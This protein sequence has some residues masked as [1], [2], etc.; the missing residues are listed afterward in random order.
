[1]VFEIEGR[2]LTLY[3]D[4]VDVDD[5]DGKAFLAAISH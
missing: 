3:G 5:D 4:D 1:M 2:A